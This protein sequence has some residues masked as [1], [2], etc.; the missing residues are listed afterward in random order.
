MGAAEDSG[1]RG[2]AYTCH[3]DFIRGSCSY[4]RLTATI[5]KAAS[6]LA[7]AARSAATTC[8]LADRLRYASTDDVYVI[9]VTAA[10]D[11]ENLHAFGYCGLS[12]KY[13]R[14]IGRRTSVK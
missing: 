2:F 5:P 12:R 14:D 8:Y 7:A 1:G 6:R 9:K 10:S 11:S 4:L 3:P 13:Y